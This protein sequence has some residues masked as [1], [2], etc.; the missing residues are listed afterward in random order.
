MEYGSLNPGR[1]LDALV[2]ARV[3]GV[4]Y[5][6]IQS[7]YCVED[8]EDSIAYLVCP[9]YSTN[10]AAAFQV[11]ERIEE[12]GLSERYA[13]ALVETVIP[14]SAFGFVNRGAYDKD[15]F[16]M[17]HASPAHRCIAA[18]IALDRQATNP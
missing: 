8:P 2:A 18:L 13:Y 6:L 10:I 15:I 1:D 7:D 3:F 4:K 14:N 17:V 9:E 11:E 16:S 5:E 12:M